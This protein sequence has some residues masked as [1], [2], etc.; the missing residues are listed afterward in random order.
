MSAF[1]KEKNKEL[2]ERYPF[3]WPR[4]GWT[5][6][7]FQDYD[8]S[9]TELDSMPVGWVKAFGEQMCE[10][11]KQVLIQLGWMDEWYIV[12]LKEKFGAMRLYSNYTCEELDSIIDK[13]ET[14]SEKTCVRCGKPAT[15]YTTGWIL[16]FC[17]GC[18]NE[19]DRKTAKPITE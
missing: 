13:Y 16:P 19:R 12:Q 9:Y 14:I 1:N 15:H 17:E 5:G 10:E 6:E 8:Y 11:I 7:K 3:L 18:L 4:D 2:V